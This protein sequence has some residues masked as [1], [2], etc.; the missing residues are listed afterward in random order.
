M[1][2]IV[3]KLKHKTCKQNLRYAKH[4]SEIELDDIDT[5]IFIVKYAF[6]AFLPRD[7]L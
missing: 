6:L 7:A 1:L 5:W 2:T 3:L 4:H